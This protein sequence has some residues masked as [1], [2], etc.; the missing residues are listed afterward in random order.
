LLEIEFREK[1]NATNEG[2]TSAATSGVL[3]RVISTDEERIIARMFCA[4]LGLD[5]KK[6]N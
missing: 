5:S 6:E 3:V 4:V 1:R 2:V